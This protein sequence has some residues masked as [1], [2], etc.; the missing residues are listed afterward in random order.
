M[1]PEQITL[2]QESFQKV[3]PVKDQMAG[4]FYERLFALD[5]SVRPLFQGPMPEQGRKLMQALALVAANLLDL[6]A[7]TE[8]VRGLARRHVSYGVRPEHYATV[9]EAL[10]WSLEQGL[11]RDFTP[12]VRDAWAA[13]FAMLAEEM[14]EAAYGGAEA[15]AGAPGR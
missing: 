5:P 13:A 2:V 15:E 10:L 8:T 12:A 11:G 4:L 1:T 7:I 3:V 9:G 6:S 14:K